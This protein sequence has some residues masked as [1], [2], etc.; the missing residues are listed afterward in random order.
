[1]T[2]KVSFKFSIIRV[3]RVPGWNVGKPA[4]GLFLVSFSALEQL[5]AH[6]WDSCTHRCGYP[7]L[8]HLHGL[9]PLGLLLGFESDTTSTVDPLEVTLGEEVSAESTHRRLFQ[10][11]DIWSMI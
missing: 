5:K 3:S 10:F 1:M 8:L 2:W 11:P 7:S 6:S 4:S 9:V